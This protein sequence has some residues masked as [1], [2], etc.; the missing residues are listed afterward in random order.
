M[1]IDEP[2]YTQFYILQDKHA[3]HNPLYSPL[4]K[5]TRSFHW[6]TK[7]RFVLR[8]LEILNPP[9]ITECHGVARSQTRRSRSSASDLNHTRRE[10]GG[11]GR[12]RRYPEV[13]GTNEQCPLAFSLFVG[14]LSSLFLPVS[15][16]HGP[17]HFRR[18][19]P[20]KWESRRVRG[21]SAVYT[22]DRVCTAPNE[23][24][25]GSGARLRG[26]QQEAEREK[27]R[28]ELSLSLSLSL[29]AH[30]TVPFRSIGQKEASS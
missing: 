14:R 12:E 28:D 17:P 19:Y 16:T 2:L 27:L 26:R 25:A 3:H 7:Q 23:K 30:T 4:H 29:L 20:D 18:M 22:Y 9:G 1:Y 24:Q 11:R 10:G 5:S 13:A 8:E 15:P 6:Q 21:Q